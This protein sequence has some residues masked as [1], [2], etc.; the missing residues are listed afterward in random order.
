MILVAGGNETL[1]T[2]LPTLL[3]DRGL[4]VRILSRNPGK[5]L[6]LV[7]DRVQIV[8]GDVPDTR[9]VEQAAVAICGVADG[10]AVSCRF[11]LEPVDE[12]GEG[13]DAAIRQA[14]TG[15]SSGPVGRKGSA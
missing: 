1:G 11:Y 12:G 4:D 8:P 9:A 7:G 10:E 6:P 5:A 13:I 2:R 3:T 15:A 14:V